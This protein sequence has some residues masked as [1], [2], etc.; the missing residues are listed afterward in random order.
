MTVP[1][2]PFNMVL[3]FPEGGL[4]VLLPAFLPLAF[5]EGGLSVLLPV[6]L[7]WKTVWTFVSSLEVTPFL[8]EQ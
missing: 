3:A 7:P 2:I 8:L 5:P 1:L 4:I 6:F